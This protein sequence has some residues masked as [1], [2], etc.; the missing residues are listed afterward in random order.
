MQ[1]Y[2]CKTCGAELYW[3]AEV[4]KLKCNYCNS[5]FSVDDFKDETLNEEAKDKKGKT[6][7]DDGTELE[8]N[9]VAY[10]C[11][12]CGAE[13]VTSRETVSTTC[14]YCSRALSITTNLKGDF[15]PKL[16]VPFSITKDQAIENYK[17]YIKKFFFTPRKF[18][19]QG[20]ISK[21]QGMY[22]PFWLHTMD[23]LSDVTVSGEIV[24]SRRSG[25][26]RI[27]THKVYNVYLKADG[28]FN[29]LPTDAS[30]KIENS[31]MDALE[32]FDYSKLTDF[33]PAFMAGFYAEQKDEDEEI[34][35][36]RA[37]KRIEEF[38]EQS[39]LK[40]VTHLTN[41]KLESHTRELSNQ[42]SEYAMLPVYL[43]NIEYEDKTYLFAINGQTG[44]VSGETPISK[45]KVALCSAG[46]FYASSILINIVMLLS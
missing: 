8:D 6:T 12:H 43:I 45:L 37:E 15:R 34:T 38:M 42:N 23:I 40:E 26:D 9:Y 27:K 33:N 28:T 7:L 17:K 4:G 46:A 3:E 25:D 20:R 11:Q 44:K 32:P 36:L 31:L 18:L 10:K 39:L 30:S 22:V 41:K 16:V 35:I 24:S 29:Q 1:K 2:S 13:V 14:A 5:E 19:E 21:I